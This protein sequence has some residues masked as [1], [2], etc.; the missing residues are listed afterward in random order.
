M[1]LTISIGAAVLGE[2]EEGRVVVLCDPAEGPGPPALPF[3]G[4]GSVIEPS[5]T[6]WSDFC[7]RVGLF[8]LFFH[9]EPWGLWRSRTP[10][11][12]TPEV[13]AQLAEALATWERANP[14]TAALEPADDMA[15]A[16]CDATLRWLVWWAER[17]GDT[18]PI[19]EIS[20]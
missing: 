6:T 10:I 20:G 17:A 7:R 3:H 11:G 1:G 16:Y 15:R 13:Q 9:P 5:A 8:E 18:W 14:R 4:G 12:I 19:I 2:D